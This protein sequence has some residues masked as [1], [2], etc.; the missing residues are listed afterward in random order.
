MTTSVNF[1]MYCVQIY[2][3]AKLWS[4]HSTARRRCGVE[5]VRGMRHECS[6]AVCGGI[7]RLSLAMK[8]VNVCVCE[9]YNCTD[10]CRESVRS[11]TQTP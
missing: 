10:A 3:R 5:G 6:S 8:T 7:N 2:S 4:R 11:T 1:N 9:W